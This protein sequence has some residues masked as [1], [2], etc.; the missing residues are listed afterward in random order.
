MNLMLTATSGLSCR[1]CVKLLRECPIKSVNRVDLESDG[2]MMMPMAI[3]TCSYPVK[4]EINMV[5][6]E[7]EW[8]EIFL[9]PKNLPPANFPKHEAE[10]I[11]NPQ[12][13][14]MGDS[15]T[16]LCL[17]NWIKQKHPSTTV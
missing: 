16:S 13:K 17:S 3:L 6:Q 2:D 9:H 8:S 14:K 4:L 5:K 15:R 10:R 11:N 1:N 12:K 7:N